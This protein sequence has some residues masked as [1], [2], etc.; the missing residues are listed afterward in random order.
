MLM[1]LAALFAPQNRR[2]VKL[3]TPLQGS[4]ELLPD[5]V[6]GTE[7]LS[8]LFNFNLALISQ[9]AGIELKSLIGQ[10]VLLELE[11]AEGGT[12]P[13]HGY[14]TR[15]SSNGSD[16]GLARYSATL[17]PW[18]WM[19]SRRYDSRL[20][21][22][23]TVEQVVTQVF[24]TYGALPKFEF[25]LSKTLKPHSYITQY[26]ES[27]LNFVQRLLE[28]EGLFY[29]FEHTPEQHTLVVVD[30]STVLQPLPLQPQ[31]R[32]HSASVTETADTITSWN[33]SR[34]LQ[35]GRVAVQ[36]FDYKQPGNL[37]P[38]SLDSVNQQGDVMPLE[39]FDFPG[40]YTHGSVDDGEVLV[41]NRLEALEVLAKTFQGDSNCRNMSPGHTFELLQHYDH[42]QG[43][44]E[45][46][47]FLLLS[48]HHT[49]GNNHLSGSEPYY[50]NSFTCVRRKIPFRP[51]LSAQRPVIS[52]P[53][54]AIV[55]GPPGEEIFTDSLGRVKLQFHWDRYGGRDDKSSCWVRVAQAWAS[56][57][58]GAVQIPRVGDEVVVSFLEGNP[59]RPLI[60][61][62]LYNSQNPPPWSLPENKTQ[63][64]FLTRSTKSGAANANFLRFDDKQGNEQILIHAERFMDTEIEQDETHS[65]GASRTVTVGGTQAHAIKGDTLLNVQEGALTIVAD[66]QH[67]QIAAKTHITLQVGSSSI[68]LTPEGITIQA[69]AIQT[70]STG[71]TFIKG[72]QVQINE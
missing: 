67:I 61:G 19:L 47:Q 35:S 20:F 3:T 46:R 49:A 54:T 41:R 11:L 45:D 57:G 23:Q 28:N 33:G 64:G 56:G 65:V 50:A 59:D 62:S 8:Q 14:I 30:D 5:Q 24:A 72:G 34:Q 31:I 25:R 55:V 10:P 15:F 16:G 68:T 21:Q 42:D 44:P 32:Y 48:V 36:T 60:T 38:V 4:Q 69:E 17:S 39:I 29:Y 53:Q 18:L 6:T 22:D 58:F 51:Q 13:I 1:D 70:Q 71:T 26:R 43:S 52:G 2:L 37:L 40:Q 9:D 27:D 7:A 63:S 12:R 66:E